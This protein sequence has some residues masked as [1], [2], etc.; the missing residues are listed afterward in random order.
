MRQTR[1]LGV[2]IRV[3]EESYGLAPGND[4]FE[5]VDPLRRRGNDAVERRA[6][7]VVAPS[8]K[9]IRGVDDDSAGLRRVGRVHSGR[10]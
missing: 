10:I 8:S 9:K 6:E 5:L 7:E 1:N 3:A 2:E 4:G